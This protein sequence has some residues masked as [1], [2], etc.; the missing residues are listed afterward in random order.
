MAPGEIGYVSRRRL[1]SMDH[2]FIGELSVPDE[3]RFLLAQNC[4]DCR[5]TLFRTSALAT[6][7][8]FTATDPTE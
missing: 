5:Q 7:P 3:Y 4:L 2:F 6:N 8:P 1:G